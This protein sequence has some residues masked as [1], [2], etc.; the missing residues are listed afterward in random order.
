MWIHEYQNWPNF[1]WNAEALFFR[2][3]DIR[4]RQGHLLGRMEGFG[5]ELKQEA[6]LNTL[7]NDVVK[8]SAIEGENLSPE[9]VRSSIA[10]RLGIDRAGL[11][12]VSRGVEGIVDMM[13]DATQDFSKPLTKERLCDWHAA[14]FPTGR[15]GMHAIAVGRWRGIM[16]V[17]PMQVVS[18]P[19]GREKVHFEAPGA[20]RLENEMQAFLTWFEHDNAIDPVLKAGIAHHELVRIHPFID[21]NGRVARVLA[22]LILFL[23]RMG[24]GALPERLGTWRL[25]V[26]TAYRI[27]FIVCPLR[28]NMSGKIITYTW[29][30]NKKV[31]RKSL[32]G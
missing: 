4:H 3:A 19:I 17:G 20:D 31:R 7:T 25:R 23:L 16:D 27:A 29:K 22:T 11:I 21:G 9:E 8:S 5:F 12:P 14:L 10:R 26:R 32:A 28:L 30:N 13:L 2:L 15:S 24:M 6:S 18:G 1:T